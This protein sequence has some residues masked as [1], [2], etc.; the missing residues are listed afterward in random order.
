MAAVASHE[1]L[2]AEKFAEAIVESYSR[3]PTTF[4]NVFKFDREGRVDP[5][6]EFTDACRE[7][8]KVMLKRL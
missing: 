4:E 8:R 3:P 5:L 7:E 6:K 1:V 2:A